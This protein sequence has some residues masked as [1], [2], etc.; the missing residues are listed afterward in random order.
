VLEVRDGGTG[1]EP[2]A[3][4]RIFQRFGR[5][6]AARTRSPDGVGLGLAIVAAIARAHGGSCTVASSAAGSTF[7]LRL[8]LARTPAPRVIDS[9]AVPV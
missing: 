2:E 3:L 9:E 8:P 7:A 4:E 1:I 6:D 5:A